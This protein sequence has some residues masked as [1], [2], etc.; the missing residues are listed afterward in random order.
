LKIRLSRLRSIHTHNRHRLLARR[1]GFLTRIGYVH[2]E[3]TENLA[4]AFNAG[5][6]GSF[7]V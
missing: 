7:S 5:I 6:V 4:G 3:T 1:S 2:T